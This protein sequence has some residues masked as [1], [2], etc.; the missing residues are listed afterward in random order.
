MKSDKPSDKP[1]DKPPVPYLDWSLRAAE[2]D[3]EN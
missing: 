1:P 3:D 2:H